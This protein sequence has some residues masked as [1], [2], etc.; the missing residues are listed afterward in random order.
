M[1]KKEILR[2]NSLIEASIELN[3]LQGRILSAIKQF[4]KFKSLVDIE[5][6]KKWYDMAGNSKKDINKFLKKNELDFFGGTSKI[7]KIKVEDIKDILNRKK[8]N[9]NWELSGAYL[10]YRSEGG[11]LNPSAFNQIIKEN[12]KRIYERN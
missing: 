1:D 6:L 5:D 4:D 12:A 10:N 7:I 11:K 2:P 8:K 3:A 9:G